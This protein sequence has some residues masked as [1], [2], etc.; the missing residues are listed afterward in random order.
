MRAGGE[1]IHTTRGRAHPL[2]LA[3]LLSLACGDAG[4]PQGTESDSDVGDESSAGDEETTDAAT[5]DGGEL[6]DW[7]FDPVLGNP[8]L[9][10]DDLGER[11][12][13]LELPFAEDD[14]LVALV[15]PALPPGDE[16]RLEIAGDS[17]HARVWLDRPGAAPVLMVGSGNGTA[18]PENTLAPDTLLPPGEPARLLVEFGAYG[19]RATLTLERRVDG[20]PTDT[21][22]I[23]LEAAP[24]LLT[25]HTLPAERVWVA[26]VPVG[27]NADGDP[28]TE[29]YVEG[30]VAA[31]GDRVEVV[32][33]ED[34]GCDRWLQD[35]LEFAVSVDGEQRRLETAMDSIRDR[36]LD[37]LPEEAL[38]GVDVAHGV[39]G[40]GSANTYDYFGN[41]EVSPPVTVDGVD[42]PFGRVYYGTGASQG[43]HEALRAFL[44][45]QAVQ[46][47][48]ELDSSWLCVSHV[49]E[50]I[51]FVPDPSADKGF[52][53]L[54]AD[55]LEGLAVLD[56]LD[57][58]REL[59]RYALDHGYPTV[60]SMQSDDALRAYNEELQA[61]HLDPIRAQLMDELGLQPADIITVPMIFEELGGLCSGYA[62]ALVPGMINLI[63]ANFGPGDD[64]LLVPDPFFRD[65]AQ[66]QDA[67][68]MIAEFRA[69]M[70]DSLQLHFIDDW[71]AYHLL[72]GDVH[73][74]ADVQRAPSPTPWWE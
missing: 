69:R 70:P 73:C 42:Y 62:S 16:V 5:S 17:E 32:P 23:A 51:S 53:M 39:W 61:D 43:P 40:A 55:A 28:D 12:D 6:V 34:Y 44:A 71:S 27:C 7:S 66:A 65:P 31:L 9:D 67:D 8:N 46:A 56:E 4:A 3:L 45:D 10:D 41:L 30:F 64:H 20:A 13:W 47:P 36:G 15:L 52:R 57:P 24:L 11:V 2:C 29:A 22:T 38:V 19:A 1:H 33:G 35:E 74:G 58:A 50:W 59:P 68:P 72:Y 37:D 48:I 25:D 54:Y 14:E 63:V 60:G 49:D 26:R 18:T 21:A